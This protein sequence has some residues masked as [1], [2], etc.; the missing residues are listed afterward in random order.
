M[1]RFAKPG[2][3]QGTVNFQSHTG[4]NVPRRAQSQGPPLKRWRQ[5]CTLCHRQG[6][7]ESN[8]FQKNGR[9]NFSKPIPGLQFVVAPGC[10]RRVLHRVLFCRLVSCVAI[11]F[12]FYHHNSLVFSDESV[13]PGVVENRKSSSVASNVLPP[14]VVSLLEPFTAILLFGNRKRKIIER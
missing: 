14:K 2:A 1:R 8:C 10:L 5:F 4:F 6:H 13:V 7:R 12:L 9:P 11:A 3:K